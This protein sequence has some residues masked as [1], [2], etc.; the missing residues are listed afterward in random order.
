MPSRL[1]F[2]GHTEDVEGL[3]REIWTG[4]GERS[5]SVMVLG[6]VVQLH[7]H[8][9]LVSDCCCCLYFAV[10]NTDVVVVG[11][12]HLQTTRAFWAA[13]LI[14]VA[15]D[16]LEGVTATPHVFGSSNISFHR[17]TP[18]KIVPRPNQVDG[19][20]AVR[21]VPATGQRSETSNIW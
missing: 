6:P 10:S 19:A 3:A 11:G 14:P 5:G 17:V 21:D 1:D 8:I 9:G 4:C 20:T 15:N 18:R 2:N 12:T 16:I 7:L 13:A